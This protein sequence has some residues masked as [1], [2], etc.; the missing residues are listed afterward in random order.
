VL[1]G[2]TW[3]NV[4]WA[5]HTT[6]STNWHP[7]T[8]LSHMA[9]AEM[10]GRGPAGPHLVNAVLHAAN[11][12][13]LFLLLWRMTGAEWRSAMVAALFALHPLHVESVAWIAERKDVL[14]T[15]FLMLSIL[16]YVRH[17]QSA[18]ARDAG[19]ATV[20]P[21][22]EPT[23]GRGLKIPLAARSAFAP[24]SSGA[25]IGWYFLSLCWFALGLM[26][27]P[28]L[29][30]LPFVLLLLD[31]WPLK[32]VTDAG[33]AGHLRRLLWEK[34]S[35]VFLAAL[36]C[37]ITMVTQK[38]GHSVSMGLPVAPRLANAVASYLKY[39]GKTV[40]PAHLAIFYPHPALHRPGPG[41][42]SNQAAWGPWPLWQV[43]AG[44]A[45]LAVISALVV[46]WRRRQ[47]WLAVGWFWYIGTLVPAIGIVQVGM[48]AMAD[49]Y[50]YVPLIGIFIAC[51]W[52]ATEVLCA[53]RG[54]R[55][56]AAL[57]AVV[58]I[59]LCI[60]GTRQQLKYWQTDF[61]LFNH[62]QSVTV[63][64]Y[65]A[66]CYLGIEY[67]EQGKYD[68]ALPC[69]QMAL[70]INPAFPDAYNGLAATLAVEGKDKE[71]AAAYQA[72]LR[73]Q[74]WNGQSHNHLGET[75]WRLGRKQEAV[76]HYAEAV[77][78][79]PDDAKAHY[80]LGVGFTDFGKLDRAA[81]QF[82]QALLLQP[83]NTDA[84]DRL[85]Q[86]L[87][88]QHKLAEAEQ[89][90]SQLVR[91]RPANAE[92][93]INL[94]GVLWQLG[95]RDEAVQHYLEAVRLEPKNPVVQFDLGAALATQGRLA[96]A[97]THYAEAVRL[98][99]HDLDALNA[100]GGTLVSQR[101]FAEAEVSFREVA[102][103]CPT[104][105]AA[106]INLGSALM[107]AGQTNEAAAAFASALR[108][109]PNVAQQSLQAA[110]N[111]AARGMVDAARA[112]F[113]VA[114]WLKPDDVA[115][116]NALGS[117]LLRQGQRTEAAAQFTESLRLRPDA[118]NYR[119]VAR[120]QLAQGETREAVTNYYA[121]LQLRPDDPSV[122]EELSWLL[123]TS[124]RA[125][126]RNGAE[127]ARLAER[128]QTLSGGNEPRGWRAL[129]AAYAETGR[130]GDAIQAAEKARDL[131]L[132]SGDTNRA[133][134]V[135]GDLGLYRKQQPLR[136]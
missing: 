33:P 9:D 112:R 52:A 11:A 82:A 58:V 76:E 46:L 125:D 21:N 83:A 40:W 117:F 132:A 18:P 43:L 102:R 5:F 99:P 113:D 94:G 41:V 25:A 86:T 109:D 27:K 20:P 110:T 61:A 2:L 128:A 115:V 55:L 103:L 31:Y 57:A 3:Q 10:F 130:F 7:L 1:G 122:L 123:A 77:R 59:A 79:A 32:R 22:Q 47:P 15:F 95:R 73:L 108:L 100:L 54:G 126:E 98:K 4:D 66:W 62:A 70:K 35:F 8:W 19:S 135:E 118:D 105:A 26:S 34:A 24:V 37:A 69:F 131:A 129:A 39:L 101:K 93:H 44:A 90:F 17:A 12:V 124:H 30:T 56:W 107:M 114:L 53:M 106:Q 29:V 50:T 49:R 38:I 84:L 74:P 97:A 120:A 80:N 23:D 92:A 133:Q 121:A 13:L 51:V 111:F 64:N 45:A 88:A 85:A 63:N 67:G 89:C 87:Y 119:D 16:A 104:N 60:V 96:D 72:A 36:F 28:M 78:F 65:M 68:A 48:Q 127:A 42:F 6:R 71:A 81:E 134:R 136:Q 14:S 116:H 91:L 75:L